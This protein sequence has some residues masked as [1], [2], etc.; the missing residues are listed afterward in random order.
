MIVLCELR[1]ILLWFLAIF[2]GFYPILMRFD[3]GI[4]SIII[5]S[6]VINQYVM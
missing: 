5:G 6:I 2:S 4:R 3:A 1:A